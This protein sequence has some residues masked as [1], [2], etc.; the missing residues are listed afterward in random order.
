MS[1]KIVQ[2]KDNTLQIFCIA[3]MLYNDHDN[4]GLKTK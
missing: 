3:Y 2:N 1:K 4:F